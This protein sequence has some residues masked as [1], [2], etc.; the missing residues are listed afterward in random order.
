MGRPA[1][2]MPAVWKDIPG[3]EGKYQA[4]TEG[5]IRRLYKNGKMR[6]MTP[7]HHK[8]A[9]SQRLVVKLSSDKGKGK[10][11]TVIGVISRTFLGPCPEGCVP[12]HINGLQNDNAVRNIG[13]ISKSELGKKTGASSKRRPV[14]KV[15]AAGEPV[16][17][18]SSAREAGR[19]NNMSFM[20]VIS[21]CNG[22]V[23]K[24]FAL[25]GHNYQW[26]DLDEKKGR[27]KKSNG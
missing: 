19:K 15:N 25:D 1:D 21:R 2:E 20:T 18:Y 26:D 5:Q 10:M 3:Y 17:F 23:K 7:F 14:V 12:Y 9:G 27:K 6:L 8:M 22:K 11:L 16:A 13:Y 4:S 24:P